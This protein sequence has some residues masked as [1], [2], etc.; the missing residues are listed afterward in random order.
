MADKQLLAVR[1]DLV[2]RFWVREKGAETLRARG[3][4][5]AVR[6]M[7]TLL[8]MKEDDTVAK[9]YRALEHASPGSLGRTYFDAMRTHGFSLPGEKGSP[10]EFIVLHDLTHV[11]SGYDVDPEGEV[12]VL[13]FH[14]GCRREE[15]DPF[16][17]VMFGLASFQMDMNPSPIVKG[18]KGKLDPKLFLRALERGSRCTI[19]PTDGWDPWSV[20]N[21]PVEALRKRYGITP[22]E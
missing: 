11:L 1:F 14:A 17:F 3:L 21:E 16:A 15:K 10:P 22:L 5:W 13:A 6:T 2:R 8:G 19:D 18:S 9:R 12:Q 20:M 7:I 4:G